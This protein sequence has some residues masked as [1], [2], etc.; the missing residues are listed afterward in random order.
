MK[1]AGDGLRPISS[2]AF[3][4]GV[5]RRAST[6]VLEGPSGNPL[7]V[8]RAC[9]PDLPNGAH[10]HCLLT[11]TEDTHGPEELVLPDAE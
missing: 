9:G 2:F 6:V 3:R 11:G 10:L 8:L 7:T 5:L 1:I 4:S